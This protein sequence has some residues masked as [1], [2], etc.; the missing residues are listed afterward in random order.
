MSVSLHTCLAQLRYWELMAIARQRQVTLPAARPPKD[1]LLALLADAVPDRERSRRIL[2]ALAG[3]EREAL[4]TL[5]IAGGRMA[6]PRYRARFGDIR[7]IKPWRDDHPRHLWRNPISP[8]ERLAYLGL[9]YLHPRQPPAGEQAAVVIPDE[10]LDVLPAP[11][12]DVADASVSLEAVRRSHP[13]GD[14]LRDVA[15]LLGL[16]HRRDIR[17][18]H[19]RWLA[20]R[21]VEALNERLSRPEDLTEIRSELQTGR[22]RFLHFLTEASELV[23]VAAGHLAVTAAGWAWLEHDAADQ[24]RH[25]WQAWQHGRLWARYRLPGAQLDDPVALLNRLL[26]HLAQLPPRRAYRLDELA[27]TI[28][29]ADPQLWDVTPWWKQEAGEEYAAAFVHELIAGPL[30][31]WGAASLGRC[32]EPAHDAARTMTITPLGRWLLCGE[33]EPPDDRA[34]PITLDD[35]LSLTVPAGAATDLLVVIDSL[36]D[37]QKRMGA[38]LHYTLTQASLARAL[39]RGTTLDQVLLVLDA[40]VPDGLSPEQRRRLT[41]WAE[42]VAAVRLSRA[43][44][45]RTRTAEQMASLGKERA[46]RK[47]IRLTLSP[48]AVLVDDDVDGL[49]R[50]LDRLGVPFRDTLPPSQPASTPDDVFDRGMLYRLLVA[51]R[52]YRSLQR[53]IDSPPTHVPAAVLSALA[54]QLSDRDVSAA[55]HQA[56]ETIEALAQA[57][58]G[59]TP[60]PMPGE[61]LPVTE[62]LPLL[63][64][65]IATDG[66]VRLTYWTAGRGVRARYTLD[67]YRLEWRGE[68]AYVVG[69][70]HERRAERTFRLD[71]IEALSEHR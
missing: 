40:A 19:G 27:T 22:L 67:P 1:R 43:T 12:L 45:L 29:R 46:V 60:R 4:D 50:A 63:K 26:S 56:D 48:R 49:R 53:W 16:I 68:V 70:C 35:D 8:A 11:Q 66:T 31:W 42:E 37:W 54:E 10:L 38:D 30:R 18:L 3:D 28:L 32:E 71:R 9:I 6:W 64:R 21:D 55:Q 44:L 57:M 7:P 58:D 62:T 39:N 14:L 2:S 69:Y 41:G 24:Y 33:G 13:Q 51:A 25:L 23:D 17:P 15:L 47:R 34:V 36:C 20:L 52:V 59:W 61:G 65:A 5:I